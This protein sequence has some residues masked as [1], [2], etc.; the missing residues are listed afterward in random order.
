MK[1]F[2]YSWI[3]EQIAQQSG[4]Q[5]CLEKTFGYDYSRQI[6]AVASFL[7]LGCPGGLASL[8]YFTRANRLFTQCICN[9]G[10]FCDMYRDFTRDDIDSFFQEWISLHIPDKCVCIDVTRVERLPRLLRLIKGNTNLHDLYI[11]KVHSGVFI[12][13]ENNVPLMFENLSGNSHYFGDFREIFEKARLLG[14]PHEPTLVFNGGVVTEE[15]LNYVIDHVPHFIMDLPLYLFPEIES[16]MIK[17]REE[18]EA[19]DLKLSADA[20]YSYI[21]FVENFHE[22]QVKITLFKL[23]GKAPE[24][25]ISHEPNYLSPYQQSLLENCFATITSTDI[26][27]EQALKLFWRQNS[28]ENYVNSIAYLKDLSQS[29]NTNPHA[30]MCQHLFVFIGLI[31]KTL[32]S[33]GFKRIVHDHKQPMNL[34]TCLQVVNSIPLERVKGKVYPLYAIDKTQ[35]RVLSGWNIAALPR[36]RSFVKPKQSLPA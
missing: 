26:T 12:D 17:W 13:I 9:A 10:R 7:N 27:A 14:I 24:P 3:C 5:S 21:E 15:T 32:L 36:Q 18:V 25:T 4:L 6:M 28:M 23:I 2:A 20:P 30:V 33:K 1:G 29:L 16:R 22:H 8:E 11:D 34:N 31:F 19:E 35:E